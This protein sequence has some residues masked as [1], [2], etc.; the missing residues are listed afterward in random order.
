M[1]M[2]NER[3]VLMDLS[4]LILGNLCSIAAMITDSISATR[5]TVKGVLWVQNLSQMIYCIG[6]IALKGYSGAAQNIVSLLRN[7]AAI[8]GLRHP[9]VEWGLIGLGVVLGVGANN[10]GL[11]GWLPIIAATQYSIT[12]FRFPENERA[13]KLSLLISS[14]MFAVFSAVI[15]NVAGVVTNAVIAITAAISLWKQKF[16]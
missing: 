12:I 8:Y 13:L 6:A 7:L 15:W 14:A 11:M 1:K 9:I 5:K 4:S 3:F 10:L 16:H 2:R